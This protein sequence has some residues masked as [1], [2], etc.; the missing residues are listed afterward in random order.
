MVLSSFVWPKRSSQ[1]A[2]SWSADRSETAWCGG[3]NEFRKRQDRDRF[4]RP[5]NPQSEHIVVCSN[6]ATHERGLESESRQ[7]R[8]LT[9][10]SSRLKR[11]AS[12][13]SSRTA[14]GLEV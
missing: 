6:E 7:A 4:P 5:R 9:V 1:R 2:G 10:Q 11:F 14:R 3:R 8:D 13:P 12:T